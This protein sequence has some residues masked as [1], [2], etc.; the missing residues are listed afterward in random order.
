VYLPFFTDG[1]IRNVLDEVDG[2]QTLRRDWT[3]DA[4]RGTD[5]ICRAAEDD[6][7]VGRLP[8]RQ[9]HSGK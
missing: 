7:Q 2:E 9:A 3:I 6:S 4:K 1:L 8:L 5:G